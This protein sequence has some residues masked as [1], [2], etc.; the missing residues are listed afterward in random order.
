[1]IDAGSGGQPCRGYAS[2][3]SAHDVT[4]AERTARGGPRAN[5]AIVAVALGAVLAI[6]AVALS[7]GVPALLL[8]RT[9][10]AALPAPRFVE[11]AIAA[12]VEHS[13]QGEYTFFVGGG[14]A[15]FD[16]DADL[17]PELY[18]AGGSEPAALFRNRTETGAALRFERMADPVTDLTSVTGAYPLDIDGDRLVDLVV[19]R[20]GENMLLRGL[21][22]CR[23]E[24][25]N[26]ALGF[27]GGDAWTV[28]FSA[29]WETPTATLPTLAF[30]DYV[31]LDAQASAIGCPDNQ[32][33]RPAGNGAT[34]APSV[35]LSPG[36]CTLSM[37]FSDW[38]RSGRRD[39]RVS[40]DRHYYRDGEEQLWRIEPGADPRGYGREDGW[41]R[42]QI[43]G[44]GIASHDLTGDGYP[45]VYLT[46]QADNR[47]QTLAD[48]PAR[49]LFED[50]ALRRRATAHRPFVGDVALPSTAWHAEFDDVNADGYM[51][52]FVA[53]GNVD[54]M[55]EF[56]M[57]DPS[58]LL[59]G[60]PDGTFVEGA[61]AAGL[62]GYAR[63]RG[64]TLTDLD[65][66]GLLDLV[67][68]NRRENVD[69]YR[70]V[71]SG[72]AIAPAAMGRWIQLQL[73]Q[74]GPNRNAI[75]S[76]LEIKVGDRV[77][78]REL[79]V[80]GGHAGGELGWIHTGVGSADRAEVRVRWPDGELGP[81]Q[82][83]ETNRFAII[84]RGASAV[85][86]WTPT[87]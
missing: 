28:G 44:M 75:G 32:L 20:R 63:A 14:V 54:A 5:R 55:K 2:T 27:A 6:A 84:E 45:E 59:L 50:I 51:D 47:L 58:N 60:Q 35:P 86:P 81:W 65:L 57:K 13:Y 42:L 37:L 69:I 46:S 10:T 30:G 29:T 77:T 72:N 9:T 87:P 36:W 78:T 85:T 76:W 49:P 16:C 39:L 68:V 18:L 21:G 15:A 52:L 79:T 43:W 73:V 67:V 26:E 34:Y 33:I 3:V 40:N 4:A 74:E 80:G 41:A 24:R 71:G 8:P 31:T 19:L 38:D 11:E 82:A 12:G 83:M 62:L 17:R 56:A 66:D 22:D 70:N 7:V 53:K 64:A 25:A 48:G 23:F 1:M 61:E